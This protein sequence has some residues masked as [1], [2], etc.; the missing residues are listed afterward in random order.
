MSSQPQKKN[1]TAKTIDPLQAALDLLDAQN[2]I[3]AAEYEQRQAEAQ[4]EYDRQQAEKAAQPPT[5]IY[6]A[7]I[8]APAAPVP[9]LGPSAVSGMPAPVNAVPSADPYAR[10]EDG[11][12]LIAAH[13]TTLAPSQQGYLMALA[14]AAQEDPENVAKL[15]TVVHELVRMI[16]DFDIKSDSRGLPR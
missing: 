8:I 10:A 12:R 7:W 1:D 14:D 13:G 4:A 15:A 3:R 9:T 5:G 16:R 6:G 11:E 2:A